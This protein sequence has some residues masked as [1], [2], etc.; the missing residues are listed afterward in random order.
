MGLVCYVPC[1]FLSVKVEIQLLAYTLWGGDCLGQRPLFLVKREQVVEWYQQW[2]K[3]SDFNSYFLC[4]IQ[5]SGPSLRRCV[6]SQ[7]GLC[8]RLQTHDEPRRNCWGPQANYYYW[9]VIIFFCFCFLSWKSN[10]NILLNKLMH[11][12]KLVVYTLLVSVFVS[13]FA[14]K[15]SAL[16]ASNLT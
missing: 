2:W 11:G 16:Y 9:F 7:K 14:L 6:W 5:T 4:V 3:W 12:L 10:T 15:T 1:R 13:F 8:Q